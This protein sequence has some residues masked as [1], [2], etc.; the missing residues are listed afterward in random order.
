MRRYSRIVTWFLSAWNLIIL[1]VMLV[2][3][4]YRVDGIILP[5]YFFAAE[6]IL[7]V[8]VSLLEE[9]NTGISRVYNTYILLIALNIVLSILNMFFI[10]AEVN[11]IP[12]IVVSNVALLIIA[13][14]LIAALKITQ[15]RLK[16]QYL[17]GKKDTLWLMHTQSEIREMINNAD[18][19]AQKLSLSRLLEKAKYAEPVSTPHAENLEEEIQSLLDKMKSIRGSDNDQLLDELVQKAE[20]LFSSRNERCIRQ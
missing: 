13:A 6:G 15:T 5:V 2:T 7:A 11:K 9:R 10:I 20:T 16:E 8:V 18:T 4:Q 3:V 17:E 19:D 14:F 12:L 1:I